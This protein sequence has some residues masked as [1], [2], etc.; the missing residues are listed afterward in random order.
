MLK[1]KAPLLLFGFF[2][3]FSSFSLLIPSLRAEK[4]GEE[5]GGKELF[6]KVLT[7]H[8]IGK[9]VERI[10]KEE[11]R[12]REELAGLNTKVASQEKITSLLRSEVGRIARAYYMGDQWDL[13]FLLLQSR[14]MGEAIMRYEYLTSI[15]SHHQQKLLSYREEEQLLLTLQ[16]EKNRALDQLE[17]TRLHLQAEER[18]LRSL[19]E[20]YGTLLLQLPEGEQVKLLLS[21]FIQDWEEKG[22]PAFERFLNEMSIQTRNMAGTFKNKVTFSLSGASLSISDQDFTRSLRDSSSLFRNFSVRFDQN[23][24]SFFGEYEERTLTLKGHYE[25]GENILYFHIDRLIYNGYRLPEETVRFLDEKYDL[26][27]YMDQI[28]KGVKL[29][30]ATL[31]DGKLTL[32]FTLSL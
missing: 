28:R 9:E 20:E 11:N 17:E 27:L 10:T 14:D 30:E 15:L 23:G 31:T 25:M 1:R 8:E 5:T 3:L 12:L 26:G 19:Q 22:L 7:L 21:R 13:L 6:Q 32:T 2:F 4:D 24:L 18:L 16:T 29:K